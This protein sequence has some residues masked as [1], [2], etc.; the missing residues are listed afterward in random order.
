MKQIINFLLLCFST[1]YSGQYIDLIPDSYEKTMYYD[2]ETDTTE[3]ITFTISIDWKGFT[4]DSDIE[5]I[6]GYISETSSYPYNQISIKSA[7]LDSFSITVRSDYF[8]GDRDSIIV[9]AKATGIT[10]DSTTLYFDVVRKKDYSDSSTIV[11]HDALLYPGDYSTRFFRFLGS[12]NFYIT[13]SVGTSLYYEKEWFRFDHSGELTIAKNGVIIIY[14]ERTQTVKT[15]RNGV[16]V[17]NIVV[18]YYSKGWAANDYGELFQSKSDS[19]FRFY[20]GIYLTYVD[21]DYNII[22]FQNDKYQVLN[23]GLYNN[24]FIEAPDGNLWV[25]GS[26]RINGYTKPVTL[27]KYDG[28][29]WTTYDL[30]YE[31]VSLPNGSSKHYS[32]N[33]MTYD[34]ENNLWI[35]LSGNLI[36]YLSNTD[37]LWFSDTVSG[38]SSRYYDL[39]NYNNNG[40][41]YYKVLKGDTTLVQFDD[42]VEYEYPTMPHIDFIEGNNDRLF[43]QQYSNRRP[44]ELINHEWITSKV[45]HNSISL[46][47][48]QGSF[49][50]GEGA[51]WYY[52]KNSSQMAQVTPKYSVSIEKQSLGKISGQSLSLSLVGKTVCLSNI[53]D[54]AVTLKLISLNGRVLYQSNFSTGSGNA[55]C[56]LPS[57]ISSGLYVI[58]ISSLNNTLMQ[59]IMIK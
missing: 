53:E 17:D 42:G 31:N 22:R 3:G 47:G 38:D 50:D 36:K 33:Q 58:T 56:T 20:K 43:Y 49:Y 15:Y 19:R 14:N 39:K 26:E 30:P 29:F 28:M 13:D 12:G 21:D 16:V 6:G 51:K 1:L 57:S 44:A 10:L 40:M 4:A 11:I 32:A 8:D 23:T 9:T 55:R 48:L 52:F 25:I 27:K 34:S 35:E 2:S 24:N 37:E 46:K 5:V 59:K 7:S 18:D 45:V 41:W 54:R